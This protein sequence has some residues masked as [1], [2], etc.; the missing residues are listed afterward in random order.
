[1]RA[2]LAARPA[3]ESPA[4]ALRHAVLV[5]I[6][7]CAGHHDPVK[8]LAV[9]R[10]IQRT[11]VLRARALE[12]QDRW[13]ADLAAVLAERL[14]PGAG[15]LFP[16]LAARLALAAFDTAMERWALSAG[17]IDP[18]GL[19]ERAFAMLTPALTG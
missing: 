3:G 18:V 17:A 9:V 8:T 13:Q 16:E 19:T 5:A 2:E 1:M 4:V 6:D 11:P 10:L 7:S 15:D 12:L 14:G